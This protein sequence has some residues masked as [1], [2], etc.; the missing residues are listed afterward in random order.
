MANPGDGNVRYPR[1]DLSRI[2]QSEG[3]FHQSCSP[4]ATLETWKI[5]QYGSL[6]LSLVH[7]NTIKVN[8]GRVTPWCSLFALSF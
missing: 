5:S 1:I 6:M 2:L 4:A 7:Q 3:T 8:L